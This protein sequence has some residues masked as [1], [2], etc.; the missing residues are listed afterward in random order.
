MI[1]Q[2]K[3]H[4]V[5]A[6]C[7]ITLSAQQLWDKGETLAALKRELRWEWLEHLVSDAKTFEAGLTTY[8]QLQQLESIWATHPDLQQIQQRLLQLPLGHVGVVSSD[9]TITPTTKVVEH[10]ITPASS[11]SEYEHTIAPLASPEPSEADAQLKDQMNQYGERKATLNQSKWGKKLIGFLDGIWN[12]KNEMAVLDQVLDFE[13]REPSSLVE[14][15]D[16]PE[17]VSIP[18]GKFTMGCVKGRDDTVDGGCHS[19]EKPSREVKIAA[20][21]LAKTVVTNQQYNCCVEAGACKKSENYNGAIFSEPNHPVKGV[22]WHD[23]QSYV[24]W[25]SKETGK[26]YRLPSEAEWEYAARAGSKTAYPWGNQPSHDFMNYDGMQGK[27]RW[28]YTSPVA[29]FPANA[30]GLYDMHGNVW[31]WVQ[32]HWYDDYQGAPRDGRAWEFSGC[33]IRVVRGGSWFDGG[34]NCRSAFRYFYHA[35]RR[36]SGC[37]FRLALDH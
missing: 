3:I 22:S 9:Q 1:C 4:E 18:A 27:G 10:T 24:Q 11:T 2:G 6:S 35:S 15:L 26:P 8:Q 16:I 32:D 33:V 36:D 23:A 5:S 30:F 7:T 17:M 34:G 14:G 19:D 29:S 28:E 37:G 25:L 13:Q 20:F 31:E 21:Q 12:P